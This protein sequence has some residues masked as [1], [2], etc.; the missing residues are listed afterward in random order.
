MFLLSLINILFGNQNYDFNKVIK[1]FY[2]KK[3]VN[4]GEIPLKRMDQDEIVN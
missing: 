4:F 3:K 2:Y 1:M